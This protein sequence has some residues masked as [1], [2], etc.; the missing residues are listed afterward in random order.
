[1]KINILKLPSLVL[2]FTLVFSVN[3][4]AQTD[5][6]SL[7]QDQKFEQ[8]LNEKR[9]INNSLISTEYYK[10]QIFSGD[11][12]NSRRELAKFRSDFESYDATIFFN[13]PDYKVWV[14]NFK[15]KIDAERHLIDI[16][17][18]YSASIIIK[19]NK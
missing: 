2:F 13:T 17:K 4:F 8:L 1:M 18:K 19:P 10:I 15:S 6:I 11:N 9:K 5:K 16:K 7:L 3:T 12:K 14:G